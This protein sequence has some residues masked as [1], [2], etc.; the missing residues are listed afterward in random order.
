MARLTRYDPFE[1]LNALQR[2]F[3]DEDWMTPFRQSAF[4]TTDVYMTDDDKNM[5]VEAHMPNF[6]TDDI[7]VHVEDGYLVIQAE[8]HEE[9]KDKGKKYMVRESSTSFYRRVQL[10]DRAQSDK[11]EASL[12]DGILTVTVPMMTLEK[13]KENKIKIAS[14]AGK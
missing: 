4:P 8:K 12:D 14:K 1:E 6:D 13:T 9:D 7:D 11:I 3:F 5:V 2:Q 10:P